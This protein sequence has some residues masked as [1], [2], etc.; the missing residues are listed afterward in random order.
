MCLCESWFSLHRCPE[1]GLLNQ[2]V[3]LFEKQNLQTK[4]SLESVK[5][6]SVRWARCKKKY[7]V[8]SFFEIC[9]GPLSISHIQPLTE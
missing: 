5:Y 6:R 4:V 8:L 3:V 1:V 9:G 2:M 7:A